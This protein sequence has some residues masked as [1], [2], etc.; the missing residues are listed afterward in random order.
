M[1]RDFVKDL[2]TVKQ[3]NSELSKSK[4]LVQSILLV[5]AKPGLTI[6]LGNLTSK[7]LLESN[8]SRVAFCTIIFRFT[9]T[10]HSFFV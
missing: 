2:S 4:E 7:T 8:V 9:N 3:F 5:A 10:K 1:A 6:L